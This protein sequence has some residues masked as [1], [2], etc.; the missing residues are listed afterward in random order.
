MKGILIP[1][2]FL[3]LVLVLISSCTK[4][5]D[6]SIKRNIS[7]S[8]VVKSQS[9]NLGNESGIGEFIK[10]EIGAKLGKVIDVSFNEHYDKEGKFYLVKGVHV[11]EDQAT[12]VTISLIESKANSNSFDEGIIMLSSDCTMT[13]TMKSGCNKCTQTIIER[14]VSQTCECSGYGT[15][16]SSISFGGPEQ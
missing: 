13:C 12:T 9:F 2:F 10:A 3:F 4:E 1:Q 6:L 7:Y 11:V 16:E 8:T 15:C 5:D 14:C